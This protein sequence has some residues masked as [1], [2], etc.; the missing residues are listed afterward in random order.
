MTPEGSVGSASA[1]TL[2]QQGQPPPHREMKVSSSSA[3]RVVGAATRGAVDDIRRL[4]FTA[5]RRLRKQPACWMEAIKSAGSIMMRVSIKSMS[6]AQQRTF[7]GR[8]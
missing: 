6:A 4:W 1:S 8:R 2:S 7:V 3:P 5:I